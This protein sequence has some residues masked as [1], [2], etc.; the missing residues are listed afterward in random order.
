MVLPAILARR[1]RRQVLSVPL[2]RMPEADVFSLLLL[3][4]QQ[5]G[6]TWGSFWKVGE[7]W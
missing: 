1:G 7:G 2:V 6:M 3:L 5:A 4:P